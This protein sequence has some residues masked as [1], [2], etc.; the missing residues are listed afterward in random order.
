MGRRAPILGLALA[1]ATVCVTA[2]T[3]LL[4]LDEFSA[5]RDAATD[6]S[7]DGA[8]DA[9]P[10]EG[11][12]S[13]CSGA[14][15]D[16]KND[17][18]HCGA[19]DI[20]CK[21]T[22]CKAALCQPFTAAANGTVPAGIVWDG[23]YAYWAVT[24]SPNEAAWIQRVNPEE[25]VSGVDGGGVATRSLGPVTAT[26]LDR[27]G[28][29][30]LIYALEDRIVGDAGVP[31]Q[32]RVVRFDGASSKSL[33]ALA[34]DEKIAGFA[35]RD[36]DAGA[37]VGWIVET[38]GNAALGMHL[39]VVADGGGAEIDGAAA[40]VA[41]TF[42]ESSGLVVLKHASSVVAGTGSQMFFVADDG[43]S[44]WVIERLNQ[45]L[46]GNW[47]ATASKTKSTKEIHAATFDGQTLLFATEND[48]WAVSSS[49]TIGKLA[50][51]GSTG[52]VIYALSADANDV[53][54]L[55]A[56]G[57]DLAK[58]KVIRQR[59]GSSEETVVGTAA[60]VGNGA[61]LVTPKWLFWTTSG[62]LRFL[63]RP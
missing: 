39:G 16:L 26:H 45:G 20:V 41:F 62:D 58:G 23:T 2:C 36:G 3:L 17:D 12:L 32:L 52:D 50:S 63:A 7:G 56:Q 5:G 8:A 21:A 57:D 6:G 33:T 42:N 11:G 51:V 55:V 48:V 61:L 15:V 25:I 4:P 1:I 19:C 34:P 18:Q 43:A 60:I 31:T 24:R 27:T 30:D 47:S 37:N 29:G 10:C 28:A 46:D 35:L 38:K 53:Y 14:C 59:R 9:G 49:M 54:A 13:L 44:S 40:D 22:A